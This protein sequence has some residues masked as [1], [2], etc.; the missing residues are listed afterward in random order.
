MNIISTSIPDIKIIDPL[1][2]YDERGFFFEAFNQEKFNSLIGKNYNFVQ[3]NHSK[4]SKGTL[5]GLHF[6]RPPFEQGK[7]VRV[8]SGEVYDVAV[9]LRPKSKFFGK[10]V[11][12]HLTGE[13]KK[14]FWIP[15]GF[16]HGFLAVS[17][18]VEFLYKTTNYYNPEAELT[19]K[20]ND[21]DINVLWPLQASNKLNLSEKDEKGMSLKYFI[22]SNLNK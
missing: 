10:W 11:G 12:V 21:S 5:R 9:D 13:N 2:F 6:Q 8:I 1:V 20:W 16:A 14:L 7:L 19:I 15:P 4:S 3:D 17:D 22:N 18:N